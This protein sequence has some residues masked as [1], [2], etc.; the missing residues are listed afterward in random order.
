ML[1]YLVK[2]KA[3]RSKTGLWEQQDIWHNRNDYDRVA[4]RY[5]K[6]MAEMRHIQGDWIKWNFSFTAYSG[7]TLE[8]IAVTL[9]WRLITDRDKR[10]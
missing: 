7:V 6:N 9:T 2:E 1:G 8:S 5:E 4:W 10:F 3:G